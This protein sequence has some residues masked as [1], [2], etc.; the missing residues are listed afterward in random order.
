MG[1]LQVLVD[2][3]RFAEAV[4][5][6]R[7]RVPM[8]DEA[9]AAQLEASHEAAFMMSHVSQLEVVA[10]TWQSL[11]RA[12]EQGIP[13]ADWKKDVG[14]MLRSAWGAK[15][16]QPGFRL[17]T[18]YRNAMQ[19]SYSHGRWEQMDHPEIRELRPYRMFHAVRDT[20]TSKICK[21]CSGTVLPADDP[22]W[23]SHV[24]PLHHRCRSHA[25]S[26]RASQAKR[27]GI[28]EQPPQDAAQHGFGE[29]P[30]PKQ[31][32]LPPPNL[33]EVPEQLREIYRRKMDEAAA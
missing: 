7:K 31:S 9:F 24:P 13:F 27:R 2:A 23:D 15:V 3:A 5:R 21:E 11:D 10:M 1:A 14:P 32:G 6:F 16:K 26:L 12:I 25:R 33:A 28:T 4:R 17:E 18:I 19:R 29:R 30:K 22:W 8:T 20:R